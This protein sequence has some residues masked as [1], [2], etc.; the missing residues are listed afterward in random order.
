MQGAANPSNRINIVSVAEDQL[1]AA[2]AAVEF[3]GTIPPWEQL[4]LAALHIT[5]AKEVNSFG[6]IGQTQTEY[7]L[8]LKKTYGGESVVF[9]SKVAEWKYIPSW[10]WFNK[11]N[12]LVVDKAK[13]LVINP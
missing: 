3:D 6:M 1:A 8:H 13:G 9:D 5:Q 10:R 11:A 2:A 12:S 7:K 4:G